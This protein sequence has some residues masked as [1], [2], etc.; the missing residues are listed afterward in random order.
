MKRKLGENTAYFTYFFQNSAL[1]F[2]LS[3]SVLSVPIWRQERNS[4]ISYYFQAFCKHYPAKAFKY[5]NK[6]F[7][8]G[9]AYL[10]PYWYFNILTHPAAAAQRTPRCLRHSL[11]GDSGQ[12]GGALGC[13]V[14]RQEHLIVSLSPCD[15][16]SSTERSSVW[17]LFAFVYIH[18]WSSLLFWQTIYSFHLLSI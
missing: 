2:S 14:Q 17:L 15:G 12:A 3:F 13:S 8:L 5:T 6:S 9:N 1:F 11:R 10:I 16:L 18:Q 7:A 4:Y